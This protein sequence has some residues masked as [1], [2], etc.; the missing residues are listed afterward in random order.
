VSTGVRVDVS[1]FF[2][3]G[4][5]V[6]KRGAGVE[7]ESEKGDSAHLWN[8][9]AQWLGL[10]S[11]RSAV[12][13]LHCRDEHRSGLDQDWS[14][15]WPDQDWIGLQFFLKIGGSGLDRTEKIFVVLMWIFWKYQKFLLWSDFT[16]LLNHSLY[17]A[18]KGKTLLGL[19]CNSN[20]IHLWAH[21]TLTSILVTMRT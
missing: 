16:G 18:I 4:A 2:G 10:Q 1:K 6:L 15:F 5:G 8:T 13:C 12:Q 20:C 19:F 17:F 7:S 14:Q 9:H 21:I 11:A 3:A